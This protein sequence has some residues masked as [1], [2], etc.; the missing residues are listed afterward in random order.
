MLLHEAEKLA[1]QTVEH[2]RHNCKRV[3]VAGS[4]QLKKN[5][6][7]VIDL[8]NLSYGTE[9]SPRY[10]GQWMPKSSNVGKATLSSPCTRH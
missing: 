7:R 2:F 1:K 3:E 10:R 5:E 6:V 8:L 4:T 9:L